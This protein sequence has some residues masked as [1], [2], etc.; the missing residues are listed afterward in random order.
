MEFCYLTGNV[1]DL[2]SKTGK[3]GVKSCSTPMTPNVQITKEGGL[4]EDHER[5]KRLVGKLNYLTVTRPNIAYS[6]S[7]LSQYMSS[8]TI[9]HWATV[10]H[11]L[12][13]LKEAPGRGIL[14]KK[15]GHTRIE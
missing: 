8:P 2:L 1:F 5:Y 4:F 11:I 10:E 6:I 13:Y 14:Y 3:L 7:V 12:F 9:S 15:N